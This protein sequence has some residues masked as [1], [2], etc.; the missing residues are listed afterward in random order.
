MKP[1]GLDLN[2]A[3]ETSDGAGGPTRCT[4]EKTRIVGEMQ[5]GGIPAGFP[6]PGREGEKM[7]PIVICHLQQTISAHF[8]APSTSCP[9]H[10]LLTLLSPTFHTPV[11]STTQ[12]CTRSQTVLGY[13]LNLLGCT[14]LPNQILD[15]FRPGDLMGRCSFNTP[16]ALGRYLKS[17][18]RET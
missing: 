14:L 13:S 17:Q 9:G 7:F 10:R 8:P 1:L 3:T 15:S 18:T 11:D 12:L 4:S 5:G 2:L 16:Q 6:G